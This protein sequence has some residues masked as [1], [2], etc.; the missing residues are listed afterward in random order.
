MAKKIKV[1]W[2]VNVPFPEACR[3]LGIESP[4]VGGWLYSYKNVVDRYCQNIS[5]YIVSPYTGSD[6]RKIK[7]GGT[8]Y[9]VFPEKG[10]K[11]S[12][13][14]WFSEIYKSVEPDV[15][16]IH[17]SEYIHSK[18][19]SEIC[20]RRRIVLSIQ[21]MTSVYSQYMYSGLE[22]SKILESFSLRDF[23]KKERISDMY[24]SFV[25][26]GEK[27][28]NL[29]ASIGN[30]IGRT[31]WDRAN[32][33]AINETINYY[34]CQ[35]PL[36]SGF[37]INKWDIDKC[38]RHSIF[39]SQVHYPIKG[40]HLFLKALPLIKRRYPDV[41][42]Y[43]TGDNLT[44]KPWYRIA[45]YWKY[46]K[47][48]IQRLDVADN[49]CFLGRLDEESMIKAYLRAN[50]FVCPSSI[51]N[52]SNSVCE[53]QL[54]GT[55]VVATYVGGMMDLVDDGRTG[56]LYRFEEYAMLADKVCRLFEDDRLTVEISENERRVAVERHNMEKIALSLNSIYDSIVEKIML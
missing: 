51:E 20:D 4:V 31:S 2:L 5:L 42:V 25:K 23:L 54:L 8:V 11:R 26:S 12:M 34:V 27:E 56:Y 14:K 7:V 17:G 24:K 15:V 55:P 10:E 1:I 47:K 52:S 29:I 16:H 13:T 41:K 49:L 33:L 6:Y 53:A 18:I 30:V 38:E 28:K 39:L 9:Y 43:I 46:I 21:G 48:E 32:T 40:L 3:E 35:E 36:R 45:T 50:V 19:F 22:Q 37:Y 44:L